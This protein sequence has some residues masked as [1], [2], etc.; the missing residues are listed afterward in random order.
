MIEKAIDKPRGDIH[1]RAPK[2][3]TLT[4]KEDQIGL[5]IGPGGK[6]INGIKDATG[7]TAIN[8]EDDGT[9]Y[10]TGTNGTAEEAYKMIAELT[11]EYKAGEKFENAIVTRIVDF[12]AFVKIGTNTE[13]LVHI[14][15]IAPF[16]INNVSDVLSEGEQVPVIIKE[17]DEKD[18]INLSIK[19]I[20][21]EFAVKKGVEP[22]SPKPQN[23]GGK[24]KSDGKS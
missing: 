14:S 13:G 19:E 5:V 18:R 12:G 22:A 11:H 1:E 23:G 15:E 2:I 17:I 3:L 16:R 7:V 4:V 6:T 20:D 8:I 9:V 21:P 10:I 24:E